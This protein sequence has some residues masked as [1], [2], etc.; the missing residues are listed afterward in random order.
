[1]PSPIMFTLVMATAPT[2]GSAVIPVEAPK[3]LPE[4]QAWGPRP[5]ACIEAPLRERFRA[6]VSWRDTEAN[7][8][9]G[10]D[11]IRS[12]SQ[13][14]AY[15][16]PIPEGRFPGFLRKGDARTKA[17]VQME[18]A[19]GADGAV[20]SCV[21]GKVDADIY[22]EAQKK[23]VDL[24]SEPALAQEA[25]NLVRAT[26]RFRPAID[27][28]GAP[29]ESAIAFDAEFARERYEMLAPPAPPPPSRWIGREPWGGKEWPPRY[30][31]LERVSF[32]RPRFKDFLSDDKGLPKSA[33]VGVLV[34]F[35]REG[36]ATQCEV[37]VTSGDKRLDDATC[38]GMLAAK[39]QP[40]RFGIYRL[41]IEVTWKGSKTLVAVAGEG[42][43]PGLAAPVTIPPEQLPAPPPRW[44]VIVRMVLDVQGKAI[45]CRVVSP[46]YVDSIDAASCKLAREKAKY[47]AGSN[48]F[49]RPTLSGVDVRV[50]WKKGELYWT[51]Y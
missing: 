44:P 37:R 16:A 40:T 41:P 6:Y 38:A 45:G 35:A 20:K 17:W 13:S 4:C 7:P 31:L 28:S 51:G 36:A 47:T 10:A 48:G 43:M 33:V 50:D 11:V 27:A 25:C 39:N 42:T 2:M 14:S 15:D 23:F 3:P 8:S 21:P 22:D 5:P 46:S 24:P 19:I 26:R 1:M 12:A 49:G 32:N 9:G 30:D 18:L 34:N 29:V